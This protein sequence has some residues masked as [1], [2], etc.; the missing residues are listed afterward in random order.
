M[1]DIQLGPR[2]QTALVVNDDLTQLAMLSGLLTRMG[3]EVR[4]HAG[5]EGALEDMSR[6]E[7]P[8]IIVTDIYMPKIDGWRFC[9]LLRSPEYK[10]FNNI[11]ILVVSATFS[12]DEASRITV[13]LGADAFLPAPVDG[14][15]L[16]EQVRALLGG[17]RPRDRLRVLIVED[18]QTLAELLK[19]AFCARGYL[20][21]IAPSLH[22]AREAFGQACFDTA[23]IDYHLPDGQGDSLLADFQKEQPGCVFLM[24]TT[25]PSPELA[26]AWMRAGAAS[27][28]RKPFA[29]EYLLELCAKA[30]RE[31]SLLRV[32]DLLEERTR[33]LRENKQRLEKKSKEQRLLL[34][35]IDT[36]IWYLSDSETY[37]R[38]NRAHAGF[39]GRRPRDI[40]YK[41]LDEFLT[42]EAAACC[43]AGNKEAFETGQPVF[44]EEWLNNAQ[45][46]PRLIKI[47]KTPKLDEHGQVE[48][49][50]CSGTDITEIK[51]AEEALRDS[52]S[53]F[54]R[55]VNHSPDI[56][57]SYS[58][59][60]GGAYYSRR[61][62]DVLGYT[63]DQL[64]GSRNTWRDA[65]HPDDLSMADQAIAA[66]A[67]GCPFDLEYRIRT[68]WGE[69]RWLHD[70]SMNLGDDNGQLVIDGLAMDITD[71]KRAEEE[72]EILQTQLRQ[73]H[74]MEAVGTLAAGIAHEF[75]NLLQ[76]ITGHTQLLLLEKTPGDPECP[77]LEAIL[78][79]GRR[80]AILIKQLLQFS[81][82]MESERK[83]VDLNREVEQV[84]RI[85]EKTMPQA[86]DFELHLGSRLGTIHA[87]PAQIE[88]TLLN[89]GA[90]AADAMPKGGKMIIAT[91][92]A[93]ID[94]AFVK[95]NPGAQPGDYVLL[96]VTDTGH[97][98]DRK[99]ISQIYDPFFTTKEIGKGTGLGLASVYGIVKSHGGFITCD[100]EIGAG[101]TF[102]VYFPTDMTAGHV[103]RNNQ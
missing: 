65:I 50:V 59:T 54:K 28:L 78:R 38:V 94:E 4:S 101:T 45:G 72:K 10:A 86:I 55:L 21:D 44:T 87:D 97:G 95:I 30:R 27:Y 82:K 3:L 11:P 58:L 47:K 73:A 98:M 48:F 80:A 34:D 37:G 24:M 84:S 64:K 15:R 32:E 61:V 79:A 8:D 93:T 2:R 26:L 42:P 53:R 17:E 31:K 7:P 77:S 81:R 67:E 96:T 18:D 22:A 39:L 12:G 76:A 74:K 51:Q 90:N 100:S 43:K 60:G 99:T 49:V 33:E 56:V 68:A 103:G 40:A 25:D 35:G 1:A 13:D 57:Y 75:N 69:W 23:V 52:E 5:V 6:S 91:K 14:Q 9:R 66:A 36:Q 88:Q 92:N 85:L 63:P 89:L 83:P 46:R 20:A 70:R 71:R 62:L 41:K 19:K 29:P 102:R 16:G